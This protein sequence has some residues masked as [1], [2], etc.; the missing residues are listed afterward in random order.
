MQINK[1]KATNIE[2]TMA[3]KQYVEDK[4]LA[5]AKLTVNYEPVATIDIEVGKETEHHNKGNIFK[6]EA[7]ME[8]PGDVI[9]V[10]V[11]DEDL[12]AAIDKC[13]DRLKARL[14]DEKDAMV[15]RRVH[16]KEE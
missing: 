15:E 1:I 2:L 5:L 3:I 14:A 7:T 12:Y 11:T 4:F 9:R 8:I 13:K 6:C 10:E 16:Q